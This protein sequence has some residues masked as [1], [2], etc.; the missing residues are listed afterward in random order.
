MDIYL[1]EIRKIQG[2]IIDSTPKE[3]E[4]DEFND[5]FAMSP[6]TFGGLL[7][8][9]DEAAVQTEDLKAKLTA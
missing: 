4:G 2:Y 7:A 9:A 8:L 5:Y 6:E 1:S 3:G